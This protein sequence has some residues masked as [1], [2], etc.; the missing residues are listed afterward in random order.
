MHHVSTNPSLL[1]QWT[2]SR[3]Y[4]ANPPMSLKACPLLMAANLDKSKGRNPHYRVRTPAGAY[5][6]KFLVFGTGNIIIAGAKS[7]S[8]AI[9]AAT[10]MTRM[11]SLQTPDS[12]LLW[13]SMH[14]A[15]NAVLTGRLKYKVDDSIKTHPLTNYSSKFPG[16]ALRVSHKG[17][18][19]E[20]YL[21][22]SMIII[23]GVTE[24]VATVRVI[25]DI[26]DITATARS[27][28]VI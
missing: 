15:P 5:D 27:A 25:E 3:L 2:A 19:P 18:T 21:R 24:A 12:R 28:A 9:L 4:R 11:L 26:V 22:K 23:P 1:S 7:H 10:R 16:I 13:P 14:A 6:G 17:V 20:L 8:A